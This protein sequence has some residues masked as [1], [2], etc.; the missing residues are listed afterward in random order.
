MEINGIEIDDRLRNFLKKYYMLIDKSLVLSLGYKNYLEH[1][2]TPDKDFYPVIFDEIV[3]KNKKKIQ[4]VACEVYINHD[5]IY[6]LSG[7]KSSP[8]LQEIQINDNKQFYFEDGS[9]DIV[10]TTDCKDEFT[11][12]KL[13]L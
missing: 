9:C 3:F 7:W 5:N 12:W 10:I 8:L 13:V 1:M 11:K 6:Q 2:T 4:C